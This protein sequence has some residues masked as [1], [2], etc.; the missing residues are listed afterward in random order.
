[1]HTSYSNLLKVSGL[2]CQ[3]AAHFSTDSCSLLHLPFI[4]RRKRQRSPE[5]VQ[6]MPSEQAS[7]VAKEKIW[8][9]HLDK[10][11]L[12]ERRHRVEHPVFRRNPFTMALHDRP[13]AES[14]NR[15]SDRFLDRDKAA[16][17]AILKQLG[18][19]AK[20]LTEG[21]DDDEFAVPLPLPADTNTSGG[22]G[23]V[24]GAPSVGPTPSI[25]ST[26]VTEDDADTKVLKKLLAQVHQTPHEKYNFPM[27]TAQE[28]GWIP[29]IRKAKEDQRFRFGIKNSE[30]TKFAGH[31]SIGDRK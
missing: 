14:I 27:T 6:A 22:R 21:D 16:L 8:K 9:E 1:M 23:S 4:R 15:R 20:E 25:A 13:L 11:A 19:R 12:Q 28:L 26:K 2:F 30:I 10:C 17:S 18:P 31:K 29:P 5:Q 3:K 7:A 24:I